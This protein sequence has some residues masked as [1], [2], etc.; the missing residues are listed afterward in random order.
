M[1]LPP[2]VRAEPGKRGRWLA[3]R[4]AAALFQAAVVIVLPF[5]RAGGESALRFD[6]PS[7]TLY[8]FGR[9][10]GIDA[11]PAVLLGVV[12]ALAVAAAVTVIFGRIWCGWSCPQ[13]ALPLLA[14]WAAEAF[15]RPT[16][17]TAARAALVLLSAAVSFAL[18]G[19][20]VPPI[21]A[22]RGLSRSPVLA[23]F[24]L[25]LFALHIAMTGVLGTR[26]CR[27]VCP[28]AMLQ[29]VLFCRD[30][31]VV[32]Y[33]PA[34]GDLCLRD[35]SCVRV[36]PVGIDI[37]KGLQRECIACAECIDACAR[38]TAARGIA[39][40]VG[41]RGR[42]FRGKAARRACLVVSEPELRIRKRTASP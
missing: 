34:R 9:T 24:F 13:T 41:Y 11:F 16:R 12:F 28:Y 8:A 27:T 17:R 30:T 26:F 36:C 40:L 23:G 2:A 6:V 1:S 22:A 5:V 32:A 18:L 21:E 35:E 19:Y 20:F 14:D 4:R 15:P 33:D 25:S 3:R 37:R 29:N 31:L 10:A 7:L 39:S 42:P 38:V